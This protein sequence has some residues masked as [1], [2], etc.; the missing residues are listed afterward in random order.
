MTLGCSS[1]TAL[2]IMAKSKNC[3]YISSYTKS[4]KKDE[5]IYCFNGNNILE[6]STSTE[7]ITTDLYSW[8]N[9]IYRIS[10]I[11]EVAKDTKVKG[12]FTKLKNRLTEKFG[13]PTN[14]DDKLYYWKDGAKVCLSL[15]LHDDGRKFLVVDAYNEKMLDYINKV[16]PVSKETIKL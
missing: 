6:L 16:H 7:K 13:P 14:Y 8:K 5:V 12:L 10:L 11:I 3:S 15:L 4:D 1:K 9:F 2:T